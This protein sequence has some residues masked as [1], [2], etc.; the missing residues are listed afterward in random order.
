LPQH[1]RVG[2]LQRALYDS[3]AANDTLKA[4]NDGLNLT[5]RFFFSLF[6][7][8]VNDKT[9]L[10]LVWPNHNHSVDGNKYAILQV[11]ELKDHIAKENQEMEDRVRQRVKILVG[12]VM[13][14]RQSQLTSSA[15]SDR[16]IVSVTRA[17][18]QSLD[19]LFGRFGC[20]S[21]WIPAHFVVF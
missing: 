1:Q 19:L 10:L 9:A 12:K 18:S 5:V 6:F 13:A 16:A 4:K 2:Q 17:H 3:H 14:E 7:L 11:R 20:E 21:H 15:A 8:V